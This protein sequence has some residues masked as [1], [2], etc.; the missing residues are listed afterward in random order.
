MNSKDY[1][2]N[3]QQG[4][5]YV[6]HLLS[7]SGVERFEEGRSFLVHE[8]VIPEQRGD[9]RGGLGSLLLPGQT[10]KRELTVVL[11][12]FTAGT[13]S[14]I[15]NTAAARAILIFMCV[16]VTCSFLVS[17]AAPSVP[18]APSALAKASLS[19]TAS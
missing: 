18:S 4:S 16:R 11:K 1:L 5:V 8:G 9:F 7:L 3:S 10:S 14:G 2:R 6:L 13:A 12:A 17:G 19:S 15:H